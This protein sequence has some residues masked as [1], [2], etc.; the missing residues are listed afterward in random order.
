MYKYV[1]Y[2]QVTVTPQ[3]AG[4]VW[5]IY[6]KKRGRE[7]LYNNRAHQPANIAVLK[8][9]AAGGA[10]WNWSPGS[11]NMLLVFYVYIYIYIY[12]YVY[13]YE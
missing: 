7:L 1:C 9:W 3:F 2:I 4:K 6:D 13:K 5:G 11:E 8:S 12:V 10:E